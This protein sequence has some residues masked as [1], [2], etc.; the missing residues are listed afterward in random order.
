MNRI[1]TWL[2]EP[3]LNKQDKDSPSMTQLKKLVEI[4]TLAEMLPYDSYDST[5]GLYNN[6]RSVGFMLL[7]SP[8]TGADATIADTFNSLITEKIPAGSFVQ[9]STWASPKIAPKLD[10]W[11]KARGES[12]LFKKIAGARAAHFKQGAFTSLTGALP[13]LARNF[14]CLC[15]ISQPLASNREAQCHSLTQLREEMISSLKN[16]GLLVQDLSIH[17]FLSLLSDLLY[18]SHTTVPTAKRWQPDLT[19]SDHFIN[20]EGHHRVNKNYLNVDNAGEAHQIR[21][22]SVDEYPNE[23]ALVGM[24]SLIGDMFNSWQQYPCP[25]LLSLNF[26]IL[27]SRHSLRANL[28]SDRTARLANS[29]LGK[30]VPLLRETYQD[31][32][33]TKGRLA[34]RDCLVESLFQVV[35]FTTPEAGVSAENSAKGLF[36]AK[37]WRLN[38][39]TYLQL[40]S[41]LSALP[42]TWA[43]GLYQ[44]LK[45]W[46]RLKTLPSHSAV[47][48]LP[49][50]GES[51]GM[52]N[53][54]LLLLGR[55]GQLFFWDNHDE[56][57]ENY[58]VV[59]FR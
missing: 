50:F 4:H 21:C 28:K 11:V 49:V 14:Y 20:R 2:G 57:N 53:P 16:H 9:L 23:W 56:V 30:W 24:S 12:P 3:V 36:R 51:M 1:S 31:W 48:L 18:P 34:K 22:L 42:M 8:L 32:E 45:R 7:L 40:P 33:Y 35:L 54:G 19:L 39:D 29:K 46:R 17:G 59:C 41:F 26:H 58:N 38:N 55:R 6:Q 47:Q 13:F 15:T 44:D 10:P 43:E 27:D 5:T 37:G 25:F 52:A